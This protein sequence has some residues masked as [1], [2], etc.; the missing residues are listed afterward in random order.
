MLLN[1]PVTAPPTLPLAP[2]ASVEAAVGI[3]RRAR[4]EHAAIPVGCRIPLTGARDVQ[5]RPL[6]PG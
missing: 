4:Y 1:E 3:S 2:R 5:S 6:D